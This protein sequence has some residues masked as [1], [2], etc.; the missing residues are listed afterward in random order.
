MKTN[1]HTLQKSAMKTKWIFLLLMLTWLPLQK[2]FSQQGGGDK[3]EK[4]ER[5]QAAKVAFIT[6]R[7]NLTTAQAQQ[8]WPLYNEFEE[9]RK[10]IRKQLRM[11]R[12]D[13]QVNT[14]TDEQIKADIRKFFQL[15]QEELELEKQYAEKFLKV[16]T[17]KQVAEY[18]RAER[19]F[20]KMLL[21]RLRGRRGGGG[22]NPSDELDKEEG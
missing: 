5:V 9:A 6:N 4:A 8:F 1:Y 20:T 17:P 12:I 7:L 13:N 18:Y 16:L 19:E 11:L 21:K 10:K 22:T 15:R 14:G 2:G 3:E